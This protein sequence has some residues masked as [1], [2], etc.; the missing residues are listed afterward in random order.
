MNPRRTPP[1]I[2]LRTWLD[3]GLALRG[4]VVAGNPFAVQVFDNPQLL[5]RRN[6][7]QIPLNLLTSTL[8][9][10]AP[11]VTYRLHAQAVF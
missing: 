3:Q 11:V 10:V 1:A 4:V 7:E 5:S 9:P 6:P 8:E 2:V